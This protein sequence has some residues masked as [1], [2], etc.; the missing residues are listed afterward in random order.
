MQRWSITFDSRQAG[1]KDRVYVL[2]GV[3]TV[4]KGACESLMLTPTLRADGIY[5]GKTR[6]ELEP[7]C[8]LQWFL[9]SYLGT[10]RSA[11]GQN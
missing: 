5:I 2:Q 9:G 4:I 8:V 1:D 10:R 3:V 6:G 11:V 7:K